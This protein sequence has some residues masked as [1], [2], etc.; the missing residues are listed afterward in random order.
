MWKVINKNNRKL[1][2]PKF[3]LALEPEEIKEVSDVLFKEL[4]GNS[5]IKEVLPESLR[6]TKEYE[7]TK[8][9]KKKK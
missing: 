1:V 7:K 5:S 4:I 9:R 2:F 6:N 3:D 8:S